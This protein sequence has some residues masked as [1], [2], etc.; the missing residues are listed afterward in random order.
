MDKLTAE[1]QVA[2]ERLVKNIDKAVGDADKQMILAALSFY[3]MGVAKVYYDW[4]A[5]IVSSAM[6]SSCF[7]SAADDNELS[8]QHSAVAALDGQI[9]SG[10]DQSQ[11]AKTNGKD[12]RRCTEGQSLTRWR[13]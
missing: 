2:V 7:P 5:R 6:R 12:K 11:T 1:Q 4:F 3:M 8:S 13:L 9:S 10:K